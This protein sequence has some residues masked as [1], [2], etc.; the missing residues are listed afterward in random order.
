MPAKVWARWV[1]EC[2]EPV[3]TVD[4]YATNDMC[5]AIVSTCATGAHAVTT[6][7][8]VLCA[9]T[10]VKSLLLHLPG[11]FDQIRLG[12]TENWVRGGNMC[13]R[14]DDVNS[15]FERRLEV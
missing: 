10:F 3:R 6:Y 15:V 7:V 4:D 2:A 5:V 12:T 11:H 14:E 9:T 13:V 8:V 1:S